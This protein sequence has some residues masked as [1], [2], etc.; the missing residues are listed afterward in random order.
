MIEDAVSDAE[1]VYALDRAGSWDSTKAYAHQ[2]GILG[3]SQALV[4]CY[5]IWAKA[6][7]NEKSS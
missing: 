4:G 7:E 2:I 6:A 3:E 1:N 5:A